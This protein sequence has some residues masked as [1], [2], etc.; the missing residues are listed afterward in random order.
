M[1]HVSRASQR[2]VTGDPHPFLDRRGLGERRYRLAHG[3]VV[4]QKA[5][6]LLLHLGIPDLADA[7]VVPADH[8]IAGLRHRAS[9]G[10]GS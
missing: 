1:A 8:V 10:G 6:R 4:G 7:G 5:H 3:L 2:A 9:D